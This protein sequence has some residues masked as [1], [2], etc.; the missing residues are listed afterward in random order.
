MFQRSTL[1]TR[2]IICGLLVIL[3]CS[4]STTVVG[5]STTLEEL[6]EESFSVM[7]GQ[8]AEVSN[9]DDTSGVIPGF[10]FFFCL[11]YDTYHII[12]F[13]FINP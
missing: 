5:R 8:A 6:S 9:S 13:K 3:I 7:G 12:R 4:S 11:I 2:G 10:E 1:L